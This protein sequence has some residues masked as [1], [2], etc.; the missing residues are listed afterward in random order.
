MS[1]VAWDGT[2]LVGD[3]QATWGGTPVK[4]HKVM[5]VP[6]KGT[7]YLIGWAG[8]EAQG[9]RFVEHFTKKGLAGRPELSDGTEILV[10]CR[11]WAKVES[12]RDTSDIMNE[13]RWAIGSGAEFAMG[14]MYAGATAEQAVQIATTL[15]VYTGM[16]IEKICFNHVEEQ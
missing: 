8:N 7:T 2:H 13:P 16:G 14:A 12:G 3:C 9:I 6:Y 1:T 5:H 4:T 15:D 10:I 11:N